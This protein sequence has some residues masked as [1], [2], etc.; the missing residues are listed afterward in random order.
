MPSS[1]SLQAASKRAMSSLA[2]SLIDKEAK[3]KAF[4]ASETF[5]RMLSALRD[6]PL[7]KW[8]DSD[9]LAYFPEKTLAS[10]E[11]GFAS[12]QDALDFMDVVGD[13]DAETLERK[14]TSDD[15]MTFGNFQFRHHGLNVFI[16]FG[17]GTIV[18]VYNDAAKAQRD[19]L[20]DEPLAPE[21]KELPQ[22]ALT[23]NRP[24]PDRPKQVLVMRADLK[25]MDKGKFGSQTAHASLGA[26]VLGGL[27]DPVKKT[28]TIDL[29]DPAFENWL[30]RDSFTKVVLE[31]GSEAEL[32]ELYEKVKAAGL[33][34]VLI[35]DA[36]HTKFKVPTYTGIG[37]G[38]HWP[39]Q[40]NPFT[41]HLKLFKR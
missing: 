29:S 3:R 27:H 17:Q 16:M 18:S 25:K 34:A 35:K 1:S 39:K 2:Q 8:I 13:A 32:L 7:P 14:A 15:T 21:A 11:W 19:A 12:V 36:G 9:T 26:V 30:M 6:S 41:D 20:P 22:M 38:P 10:A 40:V 23:Q 31:I 24:E 5:A 28:L 37:I 4:V 33:R